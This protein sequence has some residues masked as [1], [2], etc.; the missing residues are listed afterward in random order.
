MICI[1][2]R[3]SDEASQSYFLPF[4]EYYHYKELVY[5][6][7]YKSVRLLQEFSSKYMEQGRRPAPYISVLFIGKHFTQPD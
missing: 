5:G 3:K 2:F 7:L 1:M 4:L 6:A